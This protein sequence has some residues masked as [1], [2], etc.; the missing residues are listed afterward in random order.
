[1]WISIDLSHNKMDFKFKKQAYNFISRN[2][3]ILKFKN[4]QNHH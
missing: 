1:M 3:V 4:Q 2:K